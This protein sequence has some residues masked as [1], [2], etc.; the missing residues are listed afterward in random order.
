MEISITEAL[1]GKSTSIK[2]KEYLSSEAYI[3]PFLEK[4]SKYTDKFIFYSL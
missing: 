3:T 2:G 1:A 4:L